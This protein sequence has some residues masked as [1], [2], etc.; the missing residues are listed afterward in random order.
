MVFSV[1]SILVIIGYLIGRSTKKS[2]KI[3]TIEPPAKPETA[4]KETVKTK[5][6]AEETPEKKNEV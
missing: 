4:T 1:I 5:L 6:A 2:E 3:L